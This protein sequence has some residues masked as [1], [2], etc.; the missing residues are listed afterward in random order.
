VL[1]VAVAGFAG[2]RLDLLGGGVP[3]G[4]REGEDEG[5]RSEE[6]AYHRYGSPYD[7]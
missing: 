6:E 3:C 2:A 1:A 4:H 7:S 5:K